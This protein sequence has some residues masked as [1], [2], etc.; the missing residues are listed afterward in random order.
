LEAD[1]VVVLFSEPSHPEPEPL[2]AETGNCY[3]SKSVEHP[4]MRDRHLLPAVSAVPL[5]VTKLALL[6]SMSVSSVSVYWSGLICG[7]EGIRL[8]SSNV[9]S[10]GRDCKGC[11]RRNE[12]PADVEN[13]PDVDLLFRLAIEFANRVV[14]DELPGGRM[15]LAAVREDKAGVE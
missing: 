6:T 1:G 7:S 15:V 11:E 8:I 2:P 13:P 3:D 9:S 14:L 5:V 12:L 4:S 10:G